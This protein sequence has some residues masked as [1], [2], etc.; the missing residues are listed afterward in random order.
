MANVLLYV[1]FGLLLASLLF[2]AHERKV[3][4][5]LG[6]YLSFVIRNV[7]WL[8][9][10]A[11]QID[12]LSQDN[13]IGSLDPYMA[14]FIVVTIVIQFCIILLLL[15]SEYARDHLHR[16]NRLT[17]HSNEAHLESLRAGSERHGIPWHV[18]HRDRL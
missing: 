9:L 14:R 6:T 3:I 10:T 17:L 2:L 7:L 5:P 16:V 4:S 11:L 12:L 8:I 1:Q 15:Y 18:E 13:L